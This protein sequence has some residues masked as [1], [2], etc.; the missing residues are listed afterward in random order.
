M[1]RIISNVYMRRVP[2]TSYGM[3]CL[4]GRV[5]ASATAGQRLFS[6]IPGSGKYNGKS[7]IG[8]PPYM[9]FIIKMLKWVSIV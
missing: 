1:D 2:M 8:S 6:S 7:T 5:V 3:H 9:G 4:V